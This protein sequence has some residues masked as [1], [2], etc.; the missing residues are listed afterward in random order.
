MNSPNHKFLRPLMKCLILAGM[1]AYAL[2]GGPV[3]TAEPMTVWFDKPGRS[4]HESS[5]VGNGRLGAMDYG[6]VARDRIVLNESSMWS[7]GSY[8]ANKYDAYQCLPEVRAR[9][10]AGEIAGAGAVLNRSFRYADGVRGW[11]DE[12]QFGCYQILSDLTLTFGAESGIRITS[13]SGHAEGDGKTI[14]GCVDGNIRTKWCVQNARPTVKWQVELPE[15]KTVESYTLTSADDVP[16]RDPQ[17][18]VLE[19]STDGEAWRELDRRSFDKP[20]EERFETKRFEIAQPGGYRFYRFTFTPRNA[21]FQVAE[22]VLAGVQTDETG[23]VP[24]DYRREVNL[25]TGVATTRYTQDDVTIT[26]ELVASKPNKVIALRVKAS[27]PGALTF[28]AALSRQKSAATR[29]ERAMQLLEGQLPFNKPGGGGEGIRY[30]ALLGARVKGGKVSTT[31]RGLR[32]EDADEAVLVVSAGTDLFEEDYAA[33]TRQRL[34][35]ALDKP[36]DALIRDAVAD[37]QQYMERCRLTLP[38]GP[39]A[40]LPTPQRVRRNEQTPDPSLAA[41]YFQFGRYLT[42]AGSRPDSQLPTNL[43]GIWAEEYSTP[44]RGDFHSNINL[45]MNYWPA[46]V[47]NLSDCHRPL[48]RFLQGVAREGTKTAKAYYNAPGWMA[49][50]TQ[51]PWF[52]TAPSYLP[53]CIGP[54]C[55]AWLAQHLWTHYQFTLDKEFLRANYPVLRGAA[56][57]CM[58]VLVEDPKHH[59]LATSPSNSPENAY[60]YTDKAGK[61]QRTALCIGATYDMQ[62]IRGLLTCTAQAARILGTDTG[63]AEKLDVTRA[64]LAP[65]RVNTEGRIMEW[66][67]DFE[68]AEIHHRHCSHLWGLYPGDEI[69]PNTPELY[70]GARL[71]LERRGDASTG[72]SMAWKANF[73]ARLRDGDR[74]AKL[75]SM[76]IGRGAG[77]LMCLHP[78]F[79]IDG[80]FGGCAAV[81]EML[82]QSH[83][84]TITLLPALPAAW[85]QGNVTGLR[86]RGGHTVDIEWTNGKVTNY[87]IACPTPCEVKICVNGE[88]KTVMAEAL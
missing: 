4:F 78:P 68:E 74:A 28:G 3:V 31:D 23:P 49:N 42:V 33:I 39:D 11:G 75:L 17:V 55:G 50:H 43:Q 61:K 69:N 8:E 32:I 40:A 58:A 10:F 15:E 19:G 20:F 36:F 6:G 52:E 76:L 77:N 27:R 44:W 16:I 5:I 88:M 37:H 87:R 7:G 12:N 21:Y 62:I 66:Q 30:Q 67:E 1:L 70:R 51:N 82:V 86:A 24:A 41:L 47:T 80:N 26:R 35:A 48:L 38:A 79:Q 53:A 57:F 46:E 85:A 29:I 65:T 45:Q 84:E 81:A 72:W 2:P 73:W 83:D 34:A 13:P 63:F 64:R 59:W 56:Q 9:L 14:A 71:S 25:M 60:V 54:T 22:I 18:W